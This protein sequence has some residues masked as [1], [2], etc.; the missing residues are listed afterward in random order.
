VN[1]VKVHRLDDSYRRELVAYK[2]LGE[3]GVVACLAVPR[4]R[5]HDDSLRVIEM[6]VVVPPFLL[7]F[8][9]AYPIE[10]SPHFPPEVMAE[11]LADKR[12]Q[13]GPDW[14]KAAAAIREVERRFG[15]RML[16]VHPANI[17]LHPVRGNRRGP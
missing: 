15:L 12:E 11:W 4:L 2:R 1:A 6:T 13:F 14:P 8:A 10:S 17:M 5:G 7:D 3:E 16:D 9:S